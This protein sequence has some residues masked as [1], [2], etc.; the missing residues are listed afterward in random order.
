MR[1]L[2]VLIAALV[3]LSATDP[4]GR[5]VRG[6]TRRIDPS[7][8]SEQGSKDNGREALEGVDAQYGELVTRDG[9]RLRT[10]VTR[11]QGA[12]GRLPAILFVQW[13][14]CDSVELKPGAGDGWSRML[15][16][17]IQESGA[18]V[19]R[20]DKRGV[21]GSGGGPC[22][23]LDYETELA[24][25]REALRYL[26]QLTSVDPER[27]VVFGA[28]MG[29][30][31]APLVASGKKVAAVIIWGAGA[32][33]WFERMMTFER[34]RRER[35]PEV[36]PARINADMK[37]VT[38]TLY[39]YLILGEHPS[40]V[41]APADPAHAFP[42]LLGV[43]A[44]THYGRPFKFHH[45]AQAQD[46]AAAWANVRAPVLVLYGEYDW[47]EDAA[48]HEMIA[49]TVNR[50]APGNGRFRVIPQTDHHFMRY[51]TAEAAF[52]EK[53]GVVNEGPVVE[54]ILSFL[55]ECCAVSQ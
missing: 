41:N 46:W 37:L 52:A 35:S 23:A 51:P 45:Q 44:K 30:N 40:P 16:R 55:R 21:G 18:V 3:S 36:P 31:F 24:D 42:L 39:R 53:G 20:V 54:Q 50:T 14:S 22:S 29:G 2:L 6:Q 28:S 32:K 26:S 27:I 34:Q 19:L 17:V 49:R 9:T 43:D 1:S 13:L 7:E 10:M 11:P 5:D 12:S 47:F 38:R 48:G 8:S 33:S 4:A 15:R 25:H